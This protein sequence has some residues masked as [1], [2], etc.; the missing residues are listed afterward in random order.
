M[1]ID[2]QKS[3][4]DD[5]RAYFEIRDGVQVTRQLE[6]ADGLRYRVIR[7][8]PFSASII[9]EGVDDLDLT[10]LT[11]GGAEIETMQKSTVDK[12]VGWGKAAWDFAKGVLAGN[13][14]I[15]NTQTATFDPATGNMTGFTNVTQVVCQP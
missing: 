2:D 7:R 8:S 3:L 15:Q 14:Y 6:T 11:E 1:S 10:M 13:C 5:L 9:I 12:I 4:P